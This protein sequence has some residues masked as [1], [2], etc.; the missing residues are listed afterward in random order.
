MQ[1]DGRQGP[2]RKWVVV[3]AAGRA[4]LTRGYSRFVGFMRWFL[5]LSAVLLALTLFAWPYLESRDDGFHMIVSDIEVAEGGRL[6]MTN[7]RFLATDEEG[8]P[9]TLTTREAWQDPANK[10]IVN[11]EEVEG[12]ILLE[13][14]AWVAVNSLTGRYDEPGQILTLTGDVSLFTDEG[15][16]LHTESASFDLASGE[17]WGDEPV[18]GQGPAGLLDAQGFRISKNDGKLRFLGR[19]HMT[20][21]PG[22]AQ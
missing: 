20:L 11:L 8:Q 5:P 7:A 17:G 19:V 2:S 18:A 21:Y 22:A 13:S 14:G 15:Y 10:D 4:R 16:E 6:S 1:A 9:Y 12:D 3:P